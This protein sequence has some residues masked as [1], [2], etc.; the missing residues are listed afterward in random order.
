[1]MTHQELDR[2][3]V[4][5]SKEYL[6]LEAKLLDVL[7]KM[8]DRKCFK[9]LG[10]PSLFAYAT[11]RLKFSDGQAYNF[12]NVARKAK[13]VPELKLAVE[14]GVLS[15]SKA[16]KIVPVIQ[17]TN[18]S[19]WIEKAAMLP[20]RVIEKQVAE[21]I[22]P[23]GRVE[24]LEEKLR[25]LRDILIQKTGKSCSR[26]DVLEWIADEMLDRHDPVRKAERAKKPVVRPDD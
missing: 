19:E 26:E 14:K 22:R 20:Q 1:M 11:N 3:A 9:Q 13:E 16:R 10:Y 25:R 5:Y 21:R 18:A 7:Q 8:D 17:R 23:P 15:V 24:Q 12:I 2:L 4:T 6:K